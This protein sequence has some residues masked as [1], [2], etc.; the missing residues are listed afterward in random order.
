MTNRFPHL[1]DIDRLKDW[2][3]C[4][5]DDNYGYNLMSPR[6]MTKLIEWFNHGRTDVKRRVIEEV[7]NKKMLDDIEARFKL[8]PRQSIVAEVCGIDAELAAEVASMSMAEMLERLQASEH[9]AEIAQRL[10][11]LEVEV[12]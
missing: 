5:S 4:N 2:L 10:G 6:K 3:L 1:A 8:S 7:Y 11:G 12:R 9:W